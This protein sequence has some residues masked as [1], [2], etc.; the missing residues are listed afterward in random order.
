VTRKG[1]EFVD[2]ETV[3][4]HIQQIGFGPVLAAYGNL[5]ADKFRDLWIQRMPAENPFPEES[6]KHAA[7]STYLKQSKAKP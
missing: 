3:G 7:P 2:C 5:S 4:H 6:V 1:G